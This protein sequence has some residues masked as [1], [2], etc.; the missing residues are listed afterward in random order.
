MLLEEHFL[1]FPD[2]SIIQTQE[3]NYKFNQEEE[4]ED[5]PQIVDNENP[6]YF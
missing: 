3:G 5:N 1:F 4:D 2:K 6:V